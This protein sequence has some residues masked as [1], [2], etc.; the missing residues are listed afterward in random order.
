[1]EEKSGF[2]AVQNKHREAKSPPLPHSHPYWGVNGLLNT[3]IEAPGNASLSKG[4]VGGGKG[5]GVLGGDYF[6]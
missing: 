4:G 3:G 2:P 1:M 6:S 5:V